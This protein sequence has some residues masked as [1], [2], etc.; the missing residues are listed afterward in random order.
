M[1]EVWRPGG[2]TERRPHRPRRPHHRARQAAAPRRRRRSAPAEAAAA[3]ARRR[4]EHGAPRHGHRHV[5]KAPTARQRKDRHDRQQRKDRDAGRG[6]RQGRGDRGDRPRRPRR[7]GGG[8]DRAEREKYFAKPHGGGERRDKQPDPNSPFAKLAAL[9]QQLE[10]D[11]KEGSSCGSKLLPSTARSAH[12]SRNRRERVVGDGS[13][14]WGADRQ[15]L[16]KWLWHARLVR[17]RADAAALTQAGHV[18]VNGKRT[19]AAGHPVRVGDVLTVALDRSVRVVEVAGFCDRRG[20]G[21]GGAGA[22]P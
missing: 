16:D 20:R 8:I 22:L 9:K 7:D 4:A 6:E 15:R 3:R 21:A 13:C 2:R 5:A 19:I 17:T 10:Q 11:G 18:R 1:I 12:D 14:G